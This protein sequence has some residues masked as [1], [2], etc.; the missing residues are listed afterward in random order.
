MKSR[1]ERSAAAIGPS[2]PFYLSKVVFHAQGFSASIRMG[3]KA[4]LFPSATPPSRLP[5][6]IP[7]VVSQCGTTSHR[8]RET[9]G[10]GEPAVGDVAG[11]LV[12][13]D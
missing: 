10:S 2:S 12:V 7:Q 6:T 11:T 9:S 3:S 5:S 8:R 1:R 4:P 13:L